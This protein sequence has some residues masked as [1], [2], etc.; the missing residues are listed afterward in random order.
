MRHRS[1][2]SLHRMVAAALTTSLIIT[3]AV[4]SAGQA[5]GTPDRPS[6][7][8]QF[9]LPF[10]EGVPWVVVAPAEGRSPDRANAWAVT[11]RPAGESAAPSDDGDTV[12]SPAAGRVR[13]LDLQ[14]P[15]APIWCKHDGVWKGPQREVALD[16]DQEWTVLLGA[17]DA[18]MVEEGQEVA[19]GQPL[20]RLSQSTCDGSRA[21]EL[22]LWRRGEDGVRSHPFGLLGGL[23]DD[24]LTPGRT[25]VRRAR[26]G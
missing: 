18:L 5:S 14:P 4:V 22:L 9:E 11:F 16:L 13:L 21:L 3:V 23:R 2:L 8:P 25:V 24:E 26:A 20:G 10:V 17:L 12:V 1:L 6:A 7:A 19:S 15:I